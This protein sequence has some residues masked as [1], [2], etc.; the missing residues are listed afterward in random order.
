MS[1]NNKKLAKKKAHERE[2]RKRV[3]DR[4]KAI[5]QDRKDEA[6]R[7]KA[8]ERE[9]SQKQNLGLTNEEIKSKLEHNLKILEALEE[10]LVKE[11][12]VRQQNTAVF[13]EKALEDM[14]KLQEQIAKQEPAEDQPKE[15]E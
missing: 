8:F 12:E 3:L 13:K 2:A 9:F 15:S 10:E 1:K 6:M 7:E 4:R 11:E 5:R 14:A